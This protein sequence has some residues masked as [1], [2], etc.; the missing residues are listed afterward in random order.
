MNGH[1]RGWDSFA[2][3]VI[4]ALVLGCGTS[5][6]LSSAAT[7]PGAASPTPVPPTPVPNT[8][9]R[10]TDAP[11]PTSS[12][13]GPDLVGRLGCGQGSEIDVAADVLRQPAEAELAQTAEAQALRAFVTTPDAT[14]M[15]YPTLGWRVAGISATRIDYLAPG[16]NGWYYVSVEDVADQGGWQAWEYGR[17]D[18][19]VVLPEGI[20]F[21]S[22][23]P[24]PDPPAPGATSL[25]VLATEVACSSGKPMAGRLLAPIVLYAP[26]AVTIAIVVRRRPG[27]Q[28]CQGN[29]PE[30]VLVDLSE[31]LG[32]RALFDGSSYPAQQRS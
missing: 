3:M 28:E 6:Q 12:V 11:S 2:I 8:T 25:T 5:P 16:R 29:T 9:S 30:P 18:L 23:A 10:P 31:P 4:A 26:E 32:G 17:C 14:Q 7:A 20:G 21:A 27:D 13:V 22:W 24:G 15:G 1:R 19:R